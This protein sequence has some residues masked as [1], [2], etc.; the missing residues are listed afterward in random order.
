MFS[1]LPS[2]NITSRDG[3]SFGRLIYET[4]IIADGSVSL[5]KKY[6][7]IGN[8]NATAIIRNTFDV[9]RRYVVRSRTVRTHRRSPVVNTIPEQEN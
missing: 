3:K 1:R 9:T 5:L 7:V 6:A 2:V 8:R 4:R